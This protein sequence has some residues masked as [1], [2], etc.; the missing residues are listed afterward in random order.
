MLGE[1]KKQNFMTEMYNK[2]FILY[3]SI[4]SSECL[5]KIIIESSNSYS[6][7]E[8]LSFELSVNFKIET[9]IIIELLNQYKDNP[10]SEKS[11]EILLLLEKIYALKIRERHFMNDFNDSYI[12]KAIEEAFLKYTGSKPF[13]VE[14]SLSLKRL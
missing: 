9:N 4:L 14:I 10:D 7:D 5:E 12:S 11:L 1:Y 3:G 6:I 8:G 2:Y 13:S